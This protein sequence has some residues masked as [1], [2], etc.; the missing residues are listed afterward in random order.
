MT[1]G[2]ALFDL[3]IAIHSI[4]PKLTE[5]Q[6]EKALS[7]AANS[8]ILD[9]LKHSPG[10]EWYW[11]A[12]GNIK[13]LREP[14]LAQHAYIKALETDS[15]VRGG[16]LRM[17]LSLTFSFRTPQFGPIWA[18]FIFTT[19]TQIWQTNHSIKHKSQIQIMDR[20]GSVRRWSLR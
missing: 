11:N 12:L 17:I 19:E 8:A 2:S 18:C 3:S 6:S 9:A 10:N 5:H 20:L 7:D 14:K 15:K 4:I 1:E 16:F 13:F